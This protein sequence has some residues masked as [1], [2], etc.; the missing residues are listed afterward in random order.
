M[1]S[2]A[3]TPLGL[4]T[5]EFYYTHFQLDAM[6]PLPGAR[7]WLLLMLQNW[8]VVRSGLIFL[9]RIG[10]DFLVGLCV[11]GEADSVWQVEALCLL[12]RKIT[13]T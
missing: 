11:G 9:I 5:K 6:K 8:C 10:P 7:Q 4:L 12:C 3:N 1:H 2:I 13:A